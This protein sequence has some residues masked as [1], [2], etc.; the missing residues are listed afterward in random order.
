MPPKKNEVEYKKSREVH[1]FF[2]GFLPYGPEI[3]FFKSKQI[4][5]K[6]L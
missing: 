1:A 3:V 2:F 6:Y 4:L 5:L